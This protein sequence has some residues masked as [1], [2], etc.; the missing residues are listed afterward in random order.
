M[1]NATVA[2][3][4]N[5]HFDEYVKR[6][7]P[8]PYDHY[9]AANA[10]MACR[11]EQLGSHVYRCDSCSHEALLHNSCRN[12]HCP[13]CQGTNSSVWVEK[14]AKNLLPVQYFHVVF[15]IPAQLNP[16]FLRNKAVLYPLLFRA[17]AET[18]RELGLN[19]K[20]LD[21]TVGF[22]AVLHTWGQNIMDHPHIHC[23]I[24]GGALSRDRTKWKRCPSGF[25][26][27]VAVLSRLFKGKLLSLL[28]LTLRK[29]GIEI[30]E[31]GNL[32]KHLY[33]MKWVVYA[34]PPFCG[35][36]AVLKYL[37]RYTHRIAISNRR[38]ISL[39]NGKVCFK[40]KSYADGGK[41]KIMTV[42]AVEFI[43]RFMLHIVPKGFVRIRHYGYLSNRSMKELL[44]LCFE[45]MNCR[46]S[47]PEPESELSLGKASKIIWCPQC[48]KG[49]LMLAEDIPKGSYR[50]AA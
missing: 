45:A 14:Q 33:S 42:S 16:V 48:K 17:V 31:L 5:A 3:I 36:Q 19:S 43:R 29:E 12:R 38:I 34:K 50:L 39:K 32:L 25:L 7:G 1:P 44:P 40:W 8:F 27:P 2:D 18:L 6:Y 23:I 46:A 11:T 35:P 30:R 28:K 21:G 47:A 10:I 20:R 13:T 26:F 9:K 22:I 41:E 49:H 24:P 15:T 4:F 37:A